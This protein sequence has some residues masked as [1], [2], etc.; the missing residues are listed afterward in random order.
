MAE[1]YVVRDKNTG[2][3]FRGKGVNRWGKHY[4]QASVYRIK[5]H[6]ENTVKKV[7]WRREQAEVMPIQIIENTADVVPKSEVD[8]WQ[9]LYADSQ[10]KWEEAYEKLEQDNI[11]LRKTIAENAQQAL[12]V[13]LEEIEK[14]KVEVVREI[15][16]EMDGV[17]ELFMKGLIE[18]LEMYDMLA[19]LKKKYAIKVPIVRDLA[20]EAV[21]RDITNKRNEE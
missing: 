8:E 16:E 4:N 13:T 19:E 20:E 15:F 1:Y 18:E 12:E 3:Y 6:A 10:K 11:F 5:A 7:S 9:K 17:T 2:L 14:T 21:D